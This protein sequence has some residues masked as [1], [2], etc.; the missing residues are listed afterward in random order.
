MI[1]DRM[2]ASSSGGLL[3][4]L[5]SGIRIVP[6]TRM[7]A[8]T[9]EMTRRARMSMIGS[10]SSPPVSRMRPSRMISKRRPWKV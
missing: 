8:S 5:S 7:I 3:L 2:S 1:S 6:W 9:P 4:K 10:S